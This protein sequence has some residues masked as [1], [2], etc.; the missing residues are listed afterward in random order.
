MLTTSRVCFENTLGLLEMLAA[1]IPGS[2]FKHVPAPGINPPAWIVGHLAYVADSLSALLGGASGLPKGWDKLYGRGSSGELPAGSPGKDELLRELRAA[3]G[4]LSEAMTSASPERL[5]S[6]HDIGPLK[7]GPLK[8]VGE[9]VAFLSV[10]HEAFHT[11][12]L[13]VWRRLMGYKPL[14]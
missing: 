11:G 8:S 2:Q 7:G 5:S 10:G 13:S 9:A 6:A 4:R 3:H 12:Q 14:F 1:D